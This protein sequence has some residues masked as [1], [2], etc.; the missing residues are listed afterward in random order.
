[1]LGLGPALMGVAL[2][3][4]ARKR[5]QI[6]PAGIRAPASDVELPFADIGQLTKWGKLGRVDYLRIADASDGEWIDGNMAVTRPRDLA[7]LV[8]AVATYAPQAQM[9]REIRLLLQGGPEK[10]AATHRR[11]P[12]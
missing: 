2:F 4:L 12:T 3:I 7:I 6:L 5:V 11:S 10:P 9:S 1:M 8:D